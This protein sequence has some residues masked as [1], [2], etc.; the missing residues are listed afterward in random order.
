MAHVP[1]KGDHVGSFLRPERLKQAR[2]DKADGKISAE[3]LRMVE[4]DEIRQLVVKQKEAGLSSITDGD[5]R[6]AWWHFD[7][8]EGLTGVEGFEAETGI[9]FEGVKTKAHSVRIVDKIDFQD[10]PMLEH[11]RFLHDLV[12]EEHTAKL[13]IPS[14]N[15]LFFRGE[16]NTDVYPKE[17]ELLR[18]VA[19][20]YKKAIQ[21]FYDEGCR[22]LQLDDTSWAVFFSAQ[23]EE[24][25]RSKGQDPETLRRAFAKTINEAVADKPDDMTITMHICRGN[26][27][28][29]HAASGGYDA[30]SKTI[31]SELHLD[32]LFLEYDDERSGGFEP[33]AHVDRKDL[34]IVLG[35]I[36]SKFGELEDKEEVKA[37]IEEAAK[38]VPLEQLCLSP[39]CGFASTEEGNILTEE[40]QWAKIKHV[41]QIAEEVWGM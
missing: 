36:T 41:L 39:Q 18:D 6:R 29:T 9:Q 33:L 16:M 27:R 10:H 25:I 24:L 1:F 17:E 15:M 38:Y 34:S 28:S 37:R 13:T 20:A 7:F 11:Y 26:F 32:G 21:A 3:E 8:L 4:D 31:F 23:G 22:Y 5:F 35:L 40:D 12:G 14:P 30:A 2:A 19:N